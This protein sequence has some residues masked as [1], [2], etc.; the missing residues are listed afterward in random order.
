MEHILISHLI[1]F[2]TPDATYGKT[3]E[4][5]SILT[6]KPLGALVDL[7]KTFPYFFLDGVRQYVLFSL[8]KPMP[9]CQNIH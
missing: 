8:G 5:F 2:P 1:I 7:A 9:T 6:A 4:S 3:L